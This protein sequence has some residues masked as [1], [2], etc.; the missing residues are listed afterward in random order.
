MTVTRNEVWRKPDE[1]WM[2]TIY[3]Y[4][5]L[6]RPYANLA[7]YY[8]SKG[9]LTDAIQIYRLSIQE[10]PNTPLLHYELGKVYIMSNEY[11]LAMAALLQAIILKP[12][13]KK[14]YVSLAQAYFYTGRHEQ[15]YE[16]I[17]IATPMSYEN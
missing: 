11:E 3:R 13:M 16:A 10:I 6:V 17:K 2:Q 15:A 14:A 1:L 5:K 9:A 8:I 4:P 7:D 12:N